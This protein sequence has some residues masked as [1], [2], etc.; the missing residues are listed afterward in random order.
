MVNRPLI[1]IML[2]CILLFGIL[3][4]GNSATGSPS[5]TP[6]DVPVT[7]VE[8]SPTLAP[9]LSLTS[10]PAH[11]TGVVLSVTPGSFSSVGCGTS[12]KIV[13]TAVIA[14]SAGNIVSSVSYKWN[15]NQSNSTGSLIFAPGETSKTVTYTLSNYVVQLNSASTVT[16]S[17]TASS[18]GNSITS[19]SIRPSGNCSLPGPFQVTNIALSVNPS[20]IAKMPCGTPI[21][22]VYTATITIAPDSN[23]GVVQLTWNI[24]NF[25]RS[26]SITFAPAQAVQ[27][28]TYTDSGKL[29]SGDS[30]GFPRSVSIASTSPNAISSATI[31]PVGLCR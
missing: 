8:L 12:S 17:I 11:L 24:Q 7:A 19:S 31:K 16:G 1:K 14:V 3:G 2:M 27:T 4:C 15:I 21:T 20:S 10:V 29:A 30:N 22:I 13:F 26:T 25:H 6:T 28:I 23:A 5:S 9:T 18:A